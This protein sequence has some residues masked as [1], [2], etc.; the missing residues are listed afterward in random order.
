L[1]LYGYVRNVPTSR[2]DLDGHDDWL[3]TA[4][5]WFYSLIQPSMDAS[6][7][8][9]SSPAVDKSPVDPVTGSTS[10]A[11]VTDTIDKVNTGVQIVAAVASVVDF[12]GLGNAGLSAAH[13]DPGGALVGM[14][15]VHLTGGSEVSIG[16][17]EAKVA[18]NLEIVSKYTDAA[19]SRSASKA[20]KSIAKHVNELNKGS[21]EA[22]NGIMIDLREGG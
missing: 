1:N 2:A 5:Q 4:K 20:E 22:H 12:T 21:K 11:M 16:L 3:D 10:R 17:R 6:K 7:S 15:L 13:N 8:K 18:K 14:A 19:L 9:G